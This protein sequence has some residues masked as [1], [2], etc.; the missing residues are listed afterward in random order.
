MYRKGILIYGLQG[1]GK[2][3][4]SK[5]IFKESTP[6]FNYNDLRDPFVFENLYDLKVD[7]I[8]IDLGT[9]K[10]KLFDCIEYI[11]T[12]IIIN[13]RGFEPKIKRPIII[14]EL[15]SDTCMYKNDA[16]DFLNFIKL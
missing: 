15:T 16:K 2:T 9:N 4:L 11:V 10:R 5:Q 14:I 3:L 12:G 6:R 13:K 8:I 7:A 1:S